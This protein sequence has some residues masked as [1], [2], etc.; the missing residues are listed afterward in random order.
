[1]ATFGDLQEYLENAFGWVEEK[2][3]ARGRRR[4][5]DHLRYSKTLPSGYRL[6]TKVSLHP[7]EEIGPDLFKEILREQLRITEDEFW[8]VV[9]G[10]GEPSQPETAGP[11]VPGIPGWLVERLIVGVGMAEAEVLR[12]TPER[13]QALWDEFRSRPSR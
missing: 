2:N 4:G 6:R 3:L 10:R 11:A 7:R 1:L 5:A 9:R 12:L 13:A 8:S